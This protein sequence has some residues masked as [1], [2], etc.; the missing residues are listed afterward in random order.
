MQV[1]DTD[2]WY[3]PSSQQVNSIGALHV[4]TFRAKKIKIEESS[5]EA[6]EALSQMLIPVPEIELP[7]HIFKG[8]DVKQTFK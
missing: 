5:A 1:D 6:N 7:E 4:T 3:D 8:R 2:H